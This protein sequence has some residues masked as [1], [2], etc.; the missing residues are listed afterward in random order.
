[1]TVHRVGLKLFLKGD[2]EFPQREL[3]PIFHRWIQEQCVPGHL[4]IDVHDYSHVFRGP[5]ILLV[6][7]EGNFS[8]DWSEDRPGLFHY[9]KHPNGDPSQ[10]PLKAIFETTLRSCLLL[11]REEAF[12]GTLQFK[13][14]EFLVVFN[15]RLLAPN[16]EEGARL[17]RPHVG[18]FFERLLPEGFSLESDGEPRERL[19]LLIKSDDAPS[20]EDLIERAQRPQ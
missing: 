8:L 18:S 4:L 16:T 20:L 2:G 3:I 9:R 14:D 1:M 12:A 7:H 10:L 15:D 19:S 5:G 11:E 17:L 13:T 6:G